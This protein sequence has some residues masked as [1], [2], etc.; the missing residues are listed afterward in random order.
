MGLPHTK[1]SPPSVCQPKGAWVQEPLLKDP[2]LLQDGRVR[3]TDGDVQPFPHQAHCPFQTGLV[4]GQQEEG[5]RREVVHLESGGPHKRKLSCQQAQ[6]PN[7]HNLQHCQPLRS[8][9]RLGSRK[10]VPLTSL[11]TQAPCV[12][13]VHTGSWNQALAMTQ[14]WQEGGLQAPAV[15]L[16]HSQNCSCVRDTECFSTS[17]STSS[18]NK[19]RF[20]RHTLFL[21][22]EHAFQEQLFWARQSLRWV[23]LS[24]RSP[25]Q[26]PG[27]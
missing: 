16:E 7:Q 20:S 5:S 25:T 18:P 14:H 19:L 24:P 3:V 4:L 6:P 11:G 21:L 23:W 12:L 22:Q 26:G 8:C 2:K 1:S 17:Q 9:P 15:D 27:R 13:P 10:C